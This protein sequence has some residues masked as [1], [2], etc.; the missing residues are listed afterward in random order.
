MA[1]HRSPSTGPTKERETGERSTEFG[2]FLDIS[3]VYGIDL[4]ELVHGRVGS[5]AGRVIGNVDRFSVGGARYFVL[6]TAPD[7]Q[8]KPEN[9]LLPLTSENTPYDYW[10]D[11]RDPTGPEEE[12]NPELFDSL[13]DGYRE[14]IA[15]TERDWLLANIISLD[16]EV[17]IGAVSSAET[18]EYIKAKCA[19]SLGDKHG[20]S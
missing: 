4:A 5:V 18:L 15:L 8:L 19:A 10:Y 12:A 13:P 7:P 20:G 9:L 3:H 17:E 11:A 2:S 1:K 6:R 16:K 14:I